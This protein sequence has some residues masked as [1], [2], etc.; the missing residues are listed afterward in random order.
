MNANHPN[1]TLRA[2]RTLAESR[3]DADYA[4]PYCPGVAHTSDPWFARHCRIMDTALVLAAFAAVAAA[5]LY[6][7]GVALR[8]TAPLASRFPHDSMECRHVD[9]REFAWSVAL[10]EGL[11]AGCSSHALGVAR[12]APV[13]SQRARPRRDQDRR[14]APSAA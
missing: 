12:R 14:P 7:W 5:A 13:R 10:R 8:H 2:P 1:W 9:D 3:R 11:P 6:V 4:S